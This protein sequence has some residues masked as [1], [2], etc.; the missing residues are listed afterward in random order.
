MKNI[1]II[2]A[3]T[4]NRGDE[5]A[6]RSMINELVNCHSDMRLTIQ[7]NGTP[8][9]PN[10]SE[11]V[12]TINRFPQSYS[13][14]GKIDFI[15]T[16]L[17]CGIIAF[18]SEGKKFVESL[19]E[20]DLVIH[21]PGGPSIGDTYH[22]AELLYLL[23]L[24]L[25]R[26]AKIPYIFYSPSM[27]PFYDKKRER[28]RKKVIRGAKFVYVRDPISYKYVKEFVPDVDVKLAMD[29]AFQ[30]DIDYV[31]YEEIYDQ[32]TELKTF[33]E[34]HEKCIG[35][36]ITDLKWHPVHGKTDI[37]V[38]INAV[39]HRFIDFIVSK[40]YG[41]LFIPQ[42]YGTSDDAT[43]M[44]NFMQTKHTFVVSA[45]ENKYDS[46]FQQY[47]I[48]KMYAVVG[49][50]Y[51][52]NIFSAKMGTPF[53]SISYE[54]KMRGFMESTGLSEYCIDLRD[55]SYEKLVSKFRQLEENYD[56]YA[57]KLK[58]LHEPMKGKAFMPTQAIIDFLES[59]YAHRR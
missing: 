9:Y 18:T 44:S 43:Y 45:T 11:T 29:S 51:H 59:K 2:H 22:N 12:T 32:Y 23:R 26:K 14:S 46:Y 38:R 21:A 35:I 20:A 56:E 33:I 24:D 57:N 47:V 48:E 19:K 17:T 27:G 37:F 54:Q 1:M 34:T 31:N 13:F 25:M 36:T 49:M 28:L 10:V 4:G 7:Y 41:V 40:G 6:V 16:Y 52:S 15:F 39:F 42:L 8:S 30:H 53:V 58:V 50:R 55:L 3:H 5:A